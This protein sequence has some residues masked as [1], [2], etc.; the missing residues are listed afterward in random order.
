MGGQ[1]YDR[2]TIESMVGQDGQ[3][4]PGQPLLAFTVQH[5]RLVTGMQLEDVSDHASH[6]A[7]LA[8]MLH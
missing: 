8:R 4:L 1:V 7:C 5:H 3:G 6:S 2:N